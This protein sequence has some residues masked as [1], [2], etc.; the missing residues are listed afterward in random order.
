MQKTKSFCFLLT[1]TGIIFMKNC[2]IAESLRLPKHE[3]LGT[4]LLARKS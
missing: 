1:E 3:R 2:K 4:W